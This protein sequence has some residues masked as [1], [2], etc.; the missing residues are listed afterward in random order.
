[1]FFKKK[2][3][4]DE[5]N[6]SNLKEGI[7]VELTK[8]EKSLPEISKSKIAKIMSN[9]EIMLFVPMIKSK[10]IKFQKNILCDIY[11]KENK[12]ISK[13][14][15][16]VL[17]YDIVDGKPYLIAKIIGPIVKIQRRNCFRLDKNII[18][19]FDM[20]DNSMSEKLENNEDDIFLCVGETIDIS[21]GGLKFITNEDIEISNNIKISIRINK[22][23]IVAIAVLLYKEELEDEEYK[24]CYKCRFDKIT[25]QAKEIITKFIFDNQRKVSKKSKI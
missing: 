24:F 11:F 19:E 1:M 18:F 25:T 23:I 15:I 13:S 21:N 16:K 5:I 4:N 2:D 20:L 12:H 3:R 10:M 8:I 9:N 22:T 17:Y 14:T 6:I 7:A